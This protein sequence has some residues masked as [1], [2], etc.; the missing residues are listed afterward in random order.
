MQPDL[1]ND[2]NLERRGESERNADNVS[3]VPGEIRTGVKG[4]VT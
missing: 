2:R 1:E 4:K 3:V